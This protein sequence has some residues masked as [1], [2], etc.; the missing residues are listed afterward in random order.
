[1]HTHTP[2]SAHSP[3]APGD[4]MMLK[5]TLLHA[6]MPGN[7]VLNERISCLFKDTTQPAAEPPREHT[8]WGRW[9]RSKRESILKAVSRLTAECELGLNPV[10]HR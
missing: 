2:P 8:C 3:P 7:L 1:M 9:Q 6:S 10:N 5:R 4:P